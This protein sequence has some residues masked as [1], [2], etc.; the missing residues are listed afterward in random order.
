MRIRVNKKSVSGKKNSIRQDC[1]WKW[2]I[3]PT[4]VPIR[5]KRCIRRRSAL[6]GGEA[7]RI[8][9]KALRTACEVLCAKA[10]AG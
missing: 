4:G 10:I 8:H 1:F 2:S 9:E 6:T 7:L 3:G 5:I